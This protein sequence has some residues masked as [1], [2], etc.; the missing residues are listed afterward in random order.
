MIEFKSNKQRATELNNV[1]VVDLADRLSPVR[2]ENVVP[3]DYKKLHALHNSVQGGRD[4]SI[5]V[6]P[7]SKQTYSRASGSQQDTPD[8]EDNKGL[9]RF[10]EVSS[11]GEFPSLSE[12]TGEVDHETPSDRSNRRRNT[13]TQPDVD[14]TFEDESLDA[15]MM[16]LDNPVPPHVE[17]PKMSSSFRKGVFD[18]DAYATIHFDERDLID[19]EYEDRTSSSAKESPNT[20]HTERSPEKLEVL[21]DPSFFDEA[22]EPDANHR[23]DLVKAEE[24]RAAGKSDVPAWVNEMDPSLINFFGDSVEYLD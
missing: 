24:A 9:F 6:L 13:P 17:S 8:R 7:K 22:F 10:D 20:N 23:R 14:D 3:R 1:E 19:D 18:F 11:D 12:V 21:P 16:E 15:G 4:S 2:Y 5:R